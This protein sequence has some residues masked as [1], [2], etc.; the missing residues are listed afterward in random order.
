MTKIT[1]QE[2]WYEDYK[3]VPANGGAEYHYNWEFCHVD[4]DG[5]PDSHDNRYGH[6]QTL[7]DC[8]DEIDII[9][10]DA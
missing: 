1:D 3:I 6:A 4:Y 9:E 7:D 8:R 10:G 5:A 2:Y